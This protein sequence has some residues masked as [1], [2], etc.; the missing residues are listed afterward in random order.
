LFEGE[1]AYLVV[2]EVMAVTELMVL[3]VSLRLWI[4]SLTDLS[5]EL[6]VEMKEV[7]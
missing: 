3:E 2:G 1:V 4:F 7:R 5:P 6:F